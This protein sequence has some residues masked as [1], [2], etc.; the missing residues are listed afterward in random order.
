M[1]SSK[2]VIWVFKWGE[3]STEWLSNLPKVKKPADV[4]MSLC[5]AG[6]WQSCGLLSNTLSSFSQQQCWPRAILL[7]PIISRHRL[8]PVYHFCKSKKDSGERS[9]YEQWPTVHSKPCNYHWALHAAWPS[10]HSSLAGS[11]LC[12]HDGYLEP[13]P[14]S[15]VPFPYLVTQGEWPY[16]ALLTM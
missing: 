16:W 9:I 6:L 8:L 12:S 3:Y 1:E 5:K 11:F 14:V 13:S 7:P 15:S 4:R 2:A 10:L